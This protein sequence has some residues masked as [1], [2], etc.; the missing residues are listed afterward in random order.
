MFGKDYANITQARKRHT[1]INFFVRLVLG[2]PRVCPGDFTG[3]VLG[4]NSVKTRD[5]PWFSPYFTQ[6]KPGK[7]GFV[8][9]SRRAAQK[10]YVKKVYVPFSLA[11]IT[12]ENSHQALR[13][14]WPGTSVKTAKM[15]KSASGRVRKVFSAL[16]SE[17][18]KTVSC[19]VRN[20]VL[21]CFAPCETGFARC[22]RFFWDSRPRETKSLLALSLK[23]FWTLWLF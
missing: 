4:T 3:F 14:R 16:R 2:R 6:G 9:G 23:H 21:G 22:E 10:V 15:P 5:K 13:P 20:C 7:P 12:F 11:N 19:T 8:P 17:S 1:N 18:P